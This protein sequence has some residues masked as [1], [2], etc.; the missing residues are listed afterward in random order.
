MFIQFKQVSQNDLY[1]RNLIPH[2]R[3]YIENTNPHHRLKH[4]YIYIA[5]YL[6]KA[7]S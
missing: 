7:A 4:I 6:E 5:D 2:N 3:N 1:K